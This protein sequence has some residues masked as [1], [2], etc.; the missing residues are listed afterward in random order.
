MLDLDIVQNFCTLGLAEQ[1]S[2]SNLTLI[3]YGSKFITKKGF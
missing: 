2:I 1:S 3:P